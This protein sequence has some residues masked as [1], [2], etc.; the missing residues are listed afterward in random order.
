MPNQFQP[1]PSPFSNCRPA[2]WPEASQRHRNTAAASQNDTCTLHRSLR[3]DVRVPPPGRRCVRC[4]L[5][6]DFRL[7][8]AVPD[9]CLPS[10]FLF[11]TSALN[12]SCCTGSPNVGFTVNC[13]FKHNSIM[14]SRVSTFW[15]LPSDVLCLCWSEVCQSVTVSRVF[16]TKLK[17]GQRRGHSLWGRGSFYF[18]FPSRVLPENGGFALGVRA[19]QTRPCHRLR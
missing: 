19:P 11:V 2:S 5:T 6:E 7:L 12:R 8:I 3:W 1:Q 13:P 14:I 10:G 17:V 15:Q 16:S 4:R 9:C 18:W